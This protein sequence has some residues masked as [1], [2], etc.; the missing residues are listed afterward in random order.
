MT[1]AF[2][3]IDDSG[4]A[5]G[6]DGRKRIF[7]TLSFTNPYTTG[8]DSF[9]LSTYFPHAFLGG[10][11][12][13]VNPSVTVA[14][15]GSLAHSTFRADTTSTSTA[16]IQIFDGGLTTLSGTFVDHTTANISG[17]TCTVELF[18]Y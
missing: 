17:A 1:A 15:A 3:I 6:P 8:G 14:L 10:R 18:G 13:A 11:V 16:V 2:T 5:N 9:S 7:G 12:V 4:S